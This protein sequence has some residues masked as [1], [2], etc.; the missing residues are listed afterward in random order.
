M[1][2][3]ASPMGSDG[4][5]YAVALLQQIYH[6]SPSHGPLEAKK[7]EGQNSPPLTFGAPSQL[8]IMGNYKSLDLLLKGNDKPTLYDEKSVNTKPAYK[9][10]ENYFRIPSFM[11]YL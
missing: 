11:D 3:S 4:R 1:A 10:G 2:F 6:H 7:Y 8:P 9:P 5:P